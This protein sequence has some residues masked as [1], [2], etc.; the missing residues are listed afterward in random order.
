MANQRYVELR[1]VELT[2]AEIVTAL[3][4]RG[5]SVTLE[6]LERWRQAALIPQ[7]RQ[8]V[9]GGREATTWVHP[10]GTLEQVSA[11]VRLRPRAIGLAEATV[12]LWMGGFDL[13]EAIVR[14][15]LASVMN[16]HERARAGLANLDVAEKFGNGLARS[17]ARRKWW[18]VSTPLEQMELVLVVETVMRAVSENRA[19]SHDETVALSTTMARESGERAAL[20]S[21]TSDL[22]AELTTAFDLMRFVSRIVREASWEDL[23]RARIATGQFRALVDTITAAPPEPRRDLILRHLERMVEPTS[24]LLVV[25]LMLR[26][27]LTGGAPTP[28]AQ[29]SAASTES[30]KTVQRPN[31]PLS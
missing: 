30:A 2:S 27:F 21:L 7:A 18:G 1:T 14:R 19:L 28:I 6:Q 8:V 16:R 29:V 22:S 23:T 11:L 4:A 5:E 25:M 3:H 24:G 31:G 9:R 20:A 15:A 17:P 10:A 26:V 13:E 12:Q